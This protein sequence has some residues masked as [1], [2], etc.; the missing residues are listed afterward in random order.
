MNKL[1][2]A[3]LLTIVSAIDNRTVAPETVNVWHPIVGH[4]GFGVASE[5]VRLHF[6]ETD[7]YL[8]P[9]HVIACARR[10]QDRLDREL[11]KSRPAI[12]PA[13]IT[14]DRPEFE[15]M[16]A[17]AIEAARADRVTG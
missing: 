8:L 6:S 15:R 9:A 11:R 7:K 2:L 17:E 4:L 12:A 3:K 16:T 10:V 1:E 14:L 5:A 13:R